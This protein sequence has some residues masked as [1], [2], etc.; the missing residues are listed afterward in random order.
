MIISLLATSFNLNKRSTQTLAFSEEELREFLMDDRLVIA[1]G[2]DYSD[3]HNA[4]GDPLEPYGLLQRTWVP[5]E[6]RKNGN[7]WLVLSRKNGAR[8]RILFSL[9][10][11]VKP[12]ADAPEL[13]D[14]CITHYCKH[15]CPFCYQGASPEGAHASAQTVFNILKNLPPL[16]E[17]VI[18]GGDATEHPKLPEFLAFASKRELI[19]NLTVR[20]TDWLQ[21]DKLTDAIREHVRAIGVSVDNA[22]GLRT[23]RYIGTMGFAN[24]TQIVAHYIP[25]L[26]TEE[27]LRDIFRATTSEK[28]RHR[29]LLLGYKETGRG[30]AHPHARLSGLGQMLQETLANWRSP[31]ISVDTKLLA[32]Y[33]EIADIADH[34]FLTFHEGEYSMYIDAVTGMA[35]KSSYQTENPV[36]LSKDI[37]A[38]FAQIKGQ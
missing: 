19:P 17:V 14:L 4:I 8:L 27:D 18:G 13:V 21:N 1:G 28:Q 35:Y 37:K 11:T 34:G 36:P 15:G 33:P 22:K 30:A 32:D 5:W 23:V 25:D 16:T 29:V 7:Y 9:D 12:V 31:H 38:I 20:G 24:E 26:G 2:S 3:F 10:P 6:T